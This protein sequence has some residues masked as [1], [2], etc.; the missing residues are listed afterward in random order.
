M[1][2]IAH[3][4][5]PAAFHA[6]RKLQAANATARTISMRMKASLI[7]K[8]ARRIRC[9]RY[10]KAI[11][12]TTLGR[13]GKRDVLAPSRWYS[14]Q[15]NIAETTYPTIKSNRKMSCKVWWLLVSKM[16]SR[17]N[18]VV[19]RRAKAMLSPLR[20]F[21]IVDTFAAKR[22]RCRSHRS[23]RKE[24]SRK[25]VVT[26]EPAMKRGLSLSAPTSEMY[27]IAWSFSIEG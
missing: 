4:R 10:S 17:I 13:V 12:S 16:L 6:L 25:M 27:A 1:N 5:I 23:E 11:S 18:P 21:S 26:Q 7:Q 14:Q 3:S 19:P 20:T 24:R 22:P 2:A 8:E 9:S 15:M